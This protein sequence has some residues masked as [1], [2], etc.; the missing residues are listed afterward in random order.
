MNPNDDDRSAR[1]QVTL[2]LD[3]GLLDMIDNLARDEGVDRTELVRRLLADGLAHRRMEAAI[4]EYAA[5]RRSAWSASALAGVDLYEMLDRIAE[6][7][8]PYLVDPETLDRLRAGNGT[9]PPG[10]P[11]TPSRTR[12]ASSSEEA[13]ITTLRTRYRPSVT[14]MLFVGESSPAGGTHFYRA[15]SNLYRATR[16]AFGVGLSVADPPEGEAFL[17]WFQELGCWLVDLADR[18][19]NRSA[20]AER[21]R[22]VDAGIPALARTIREVHP[23]RVLVLLR[24]IAPAVRRAARVADFDD[25]AIDVLPFPTRQWRPVY[26]DQ[27]AGIL[28]AVLGSGAASSTLQPDVATPPRHAIAEV[29]AEYRTPGLHSVMA[30]VL[31]GHGNAWMKSSALAREIADAD[32]WRRPGDGRHPPASQISA[33]A[34][35]RL[36]ADLFQTSDLGIRLRVEPPEAA[37]PEADPVGIAIA[38]RMRTGLN[39]IYRKRL[40][41]VFLYGSRA[42]GE[43]VPDSDVDVLIVL[44]RVGRYGEEL[45]RTSKLASD[46]SIEAGV[47]VNRTFASEADWQT[48][49]KPFLVSAR[50]DALHV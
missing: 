43:H 35:A 48:G 12:P 42:R 33:R 14:R 39:A 44:D 37:R 10:A 50:A 1:S 40:R 22:A 27:L 6:A 16:D 32:L 2:R 28:S 36:Y 34:R 8:V 38:R 9:P 21:T 19:V 46:L 30:E 47:I 23:T 31:R 20:A 13:L 26:V 25:R 11:P 17:A 41:G 49:A 29:S 5:G 18:P 45:E 4:G 3:R 7:G 24:R 15:D